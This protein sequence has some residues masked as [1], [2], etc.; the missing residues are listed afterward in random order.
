MPE[1]FLSRV[2]R[3]PEAPRRDQSI[4]ALTTAVRELADAQR[5]QAVQLKKLL[6]AQKAQDRRWEDA[7]ERWQKEARESSRREQHEADA[8]A[9]SEDQKRWQD[10]CR[11]AGGT[12]LKS[13]RKWRDDLRRV[14]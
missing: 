6:E 4:E 3:R 12:R 11:V 14:R 8:D 1:S 2:L 5:K 9:T 13:E 10:A 7:L